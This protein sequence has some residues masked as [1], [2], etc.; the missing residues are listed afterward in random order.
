MTTNDESVETAVRQLLIDAVGEEQAE[1]MRKSAEENRANR[2]RFSELSAELE[3]TRRFRGAELGEA[4]RQLAAAE[5]QL[6]VLDAAARAASAAVEQ[7]R[8]RVGQARAALRDETTAIIERMQ[9]GTRVPLVTNWQ[10][11]EWAKESA[12]LS[13]EAGR[14]DG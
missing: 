4:R 1:A 12:A 10:V 9:T 3:E 8:T 11:P 14:R 13:A 7:A 2:A 5:E 6:V